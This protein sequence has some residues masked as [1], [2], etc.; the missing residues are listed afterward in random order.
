LNQS[1]HDENCWVCG[2]PKDKMTRHHAIPQQLEPV[3]NIIISC[4]EDCHKKIHSNDLRGATAMLY[5]AEKSLEQ[6][7]T[8]INVAKNVLLEIKND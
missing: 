2:I 8:R 3:N 6:V 7:A 1:I 4:C 5:R